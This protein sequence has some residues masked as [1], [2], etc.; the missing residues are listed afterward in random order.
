MKDL[1]KVVIIGSGPAGLTAAIYAARAGLGPLLVAG[2]VPGGQLTA[3]TDVDDYPGFPLG[4]QGPQLMEKFRAQA[5]RFG[6]RFVP[7]DV[8][9]VN[10][11][12][13]PFEI[14]TESQSILAKMVILATGASAIWL[15]LPSEQRLRGRGV[16]ACAVCDGPFFKDKKVV[17]VGGGDT[18][19][20]EAQHLSHYAK[21]VLI[22]HRRDKFRAKAALQELIKTKSNVE[23][24]MDC[25]MEE[26]LGE[27][28]VT[29]VKIKNTKTGEVSEIAVEGVFVAIGHHPNTHFLD[30]QVELDD[31][32]YIVLKGETHT[33]VP[34]VFVAGDVSDPLY[35]QAVT[36]AGAGC[37]AALDA[38]A[39]LEG[40]PED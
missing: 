17:V 18:A 35:R 27:E 2:C 7:E 20:R 39:H 13:H 12:S 28:K 11:K 16:S 36:A 26:V 15:Q 25:I 37:K 24:M 9:S 23:F 5:T 1:E 19:M 21:E 4:I 10:F 31:K 32:G 38:E 6:T 22:I 33:S 40:M 30:S 3:T 8:V 14:K 34:G 29:G